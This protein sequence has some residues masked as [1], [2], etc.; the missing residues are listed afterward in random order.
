[1]KAI[2]MHAFGGPEQ[3]KF[4]ETPV[5]TPSAEQVLVD[6]AAAGVN[7]M[8]TGTRKGYSAGRVPLPVT[9]GVEGAGAVV[10]VGSSVTKFRV[11]DRVSWCF[12]Y[13]S[14]APQILVGEDSL[15][16][17]P[18]GVDFET[19]ASIMM[20]GLTAL[21]FATES[22]CIKAGDT[23]LVHAAA[24]GVGLLLTQI[25]KNSGGRVIGRV[26]NK[27]KV[28]IAKASGADEVI[29]SKSGHFADDVLRL[30]GGDGVQVVY[31][32]SGAETFNDSVRCVTYNGTLALF[33]PLMDPTP[34]IDIYTMPKS[35][36]LTY[37]SVIDFIRTPERLSHHSAQLFDWVR[38]GKLKVNI[39][40]RYPLAEAAQ[41]H[42]DL[43]SRRTTGKLLLIPE[44]S[45]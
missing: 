37:P 26:S 6:V 2:V 28:K 13:G 24:G 10:A 14:Y 41:A 11:G 22:Y 31:D 45:I 25:I 33:G 23:A 27:D 43:E 34:P 12:N 36:H 1:M 35:I 18:E 32:G 19:A 4:E 21:H 9:P 44:R 38:E 7:F 17:I 42:R 16:P 15:V 40:R 8:D 20:Q 29:V 39:A 30:T 5:K 3:L